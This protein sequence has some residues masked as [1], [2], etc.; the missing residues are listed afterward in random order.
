AAAPG[1]ARTAVVVGALGDHDE[2][3]REDAAFALPM[4]PALEQLDPAQRALVLGALQRAVGGGERTAPALVA[5][6]VRLRLVPA[7]DVLLP[8]YLDGSSGPA[9]RMFAD[10][11]ARIDAETLAGRVA[12]RLDQLAGPLDRARATTLLCSLEVA[13]ARAPLL[14]LARDSRERGTRARACAGLL[15]LGA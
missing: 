4:L 15:R 1:A 12:A 13:A 6:A 7:L 11:M 3:V 5:A 8:R 2:R 10:A 9:E 14:Q